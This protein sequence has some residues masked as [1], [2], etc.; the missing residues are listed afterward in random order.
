M[1]ELVTSPEVGMLN[2]RVALQL[3]EP[4]IEL[5]LFGKN[6]TDEREQVTGLDLTTSSGAAIG[7]ISRPREYGME[8]TYRFGR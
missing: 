5:A 4:D 7:Q 3:R 6:L 2:A 1:P 8:L